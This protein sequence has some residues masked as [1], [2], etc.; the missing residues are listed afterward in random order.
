MSVH[1]PSRRVAATAL[2]SISTTTTSQRTLLPLSQ[3]R[4]AWSLP[5]FFKRG[6]GGD[7]SHSATGGQNLDDPQVRKQLVEK[8]QLAAP[9][10][11]D[12]IFEDEVKEATKG[13][14]ATP[15]RLLASAE[16]AIKYTTDPD[17]RA[18]VR[19]ERKRVIQM[20]RKQTAGEEI[21]DFEKR[22]ARIMRSERQMTHRSPP[23]ETSMKKLVHLAHQI[24][25]K[26]LADAMLQMTYS[27]KKMATEVKYH[28]E[29]ARDMAIVSRGMG[30]G[31]ASASADETTT[32]LKIRL[33]DG[34]AHK[35]AD[36]TTLYVAEAWVNK[37]KP[38][39]KRM[40]IKGRGR[41]GLIINPST[42]IT[43]VL[44][45]EKTRIREHKERVA[46]EAKRKP[47]VHLPNRPVTAQ[48]PYYSW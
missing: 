17:P 32:P 43:I 31:K 24:Q 29:L 48:R 8:Q 42:S 22:T 11:S 47:W 5:S 36:P 33:K 37:A 27:K 14:P 40:E 16:E 35:V 13:G 10:L 12:S 20:V 46:K 21:S 7:P 38:R 25:G 23:L 45:E 2:S 15:G 9:S 44:K 26:T 1:L 4:S 41:S 30:L 28:L 6:R 34:K 18:R 3:R 19:W 39:G